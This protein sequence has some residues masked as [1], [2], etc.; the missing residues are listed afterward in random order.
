MTPNTGFS[1]LQLITWH[2]NTPLADRSCFSTVWACKTFSERCQSRSALTF[3]ALV[4]QWRP[5]GVCTPS[6]TST[7]VCILPSL[8]NQTGSLHQTHDRLRKHY[9]QGWPDCHYSQFCLKAQS[10]TFTGHFGCCSSV[11]PSQPLPRYVPLSSPRPSGLFMDTPCSLSTPKAWQPK[12]I[13]L[14]AP[15]IAFLAKS[16]TSKKLQSILHV[17]SLLT[18]KTDYY[19]TCF[20]VADLTLYSASIAATSVGAASDGDSDSCIFA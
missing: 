18:M 3:R 5:R 2:P 7:A 8:W 11:S 4:V 19:I 15:P 12:I 16:L 14:A 9:Y 17:Q 10:L 6:Q 20:S 1:L 13:S